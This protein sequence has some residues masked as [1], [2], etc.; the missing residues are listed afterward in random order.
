MKN[1]ILL[2]LCVILTVILSGCQ[3]K[4]EPV[5]QTWDRH[6]PDFQLINEE[7]PQ[8]HIALVPVTRLAF[9]SGQPAKVRLRLVN[10][11]ENPLR[12]PGWIDPADD[13]VVVLHRIPKENESDEEAAQAEFGEV[14]TT[15]LKE[16]AYYTLLELPPGGMV[17]LEKELD[18]VEALAPDTRQDFVVRFVSIVDKM[19]Y[20]S[21][22]YTIECY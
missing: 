13:N 7:I 3:S 12:I 11:A 1:H 8:Y 21:G 14:Q 16:G 5:A 6:K 18:F 17:F 4:P 9:L 20:V 10:L 15:I 22:D 2:L 19:P